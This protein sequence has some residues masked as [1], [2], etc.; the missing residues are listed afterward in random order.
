M[1]RGA[2]SSERRERECARLET[3]M[4]ADEARNGAERIKF[5]SSFGLA[6][7]RGS[8]DPSE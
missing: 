4:G 3:L 5:V 6:R 8:K 2:A 7:G 1:S